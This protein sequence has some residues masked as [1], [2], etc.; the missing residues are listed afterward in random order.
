MKETGREI[1]TG[2]PYKGIKMDKN[3]LKKLKDVKQVRQYLISLVYGKNP[4][5]TEAQLCF[6]LK[7][8]IKFLEI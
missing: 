8:V 6:V 7:E 5:F 3:K 2:H 1:S 4:V